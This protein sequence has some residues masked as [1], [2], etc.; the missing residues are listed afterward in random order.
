MA[1]FPGIAY[2]VLFG[3]G[4]VRWF[5]LLTA[6]LVVGCYGLLFR[7]FC[8]VFLWLEVVVCFDVLFNVI[9]MGALVWMFYGGWFVALVRFGVYLRC[10]WIWCVD[11]L[12][13]I[14]MILVALVVVCC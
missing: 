5:M 9:F 13:V 12:F 10:V 6:L 2:G 7:S 14:M 4:V 11:C 1:L 8:F 3:C